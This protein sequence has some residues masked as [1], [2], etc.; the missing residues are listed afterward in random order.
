MGRHKLSLVGNGLMNIRRK[1]Y[2]FYIEHKLKLMNPLLHDD[3]FEI[4]CI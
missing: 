2:L 4:L 1:K 3:A